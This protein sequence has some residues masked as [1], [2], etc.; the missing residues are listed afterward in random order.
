MKLK[1]KY[2]KV[3]F[4]SRRLIF[5]FCKV[6]FIQEQLLSKLVDSKAKLIIF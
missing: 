6:V 5:K 4:N 2:F 3:V 1:F